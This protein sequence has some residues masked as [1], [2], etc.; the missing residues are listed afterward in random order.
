MTILLG[1]FRF[2]FENKSKISVFVS[3]TPCGPRDMYS[4]SEKTAASITGLFACLD[5]GAYILCIVCT[6]DQM[7]RRHFKL[8]S[9]R[10]YSVVRILSVTSLKRLCY[11]LC[12]YIV[13]FCYFQCED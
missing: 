2:H 9:N 4:I 5:N 8:D 12:P 7:I 10:Q 1:I 6:Y 13:G 3:V 11:I